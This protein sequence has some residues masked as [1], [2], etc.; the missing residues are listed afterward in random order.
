MPFT[1][2]P[3]LKTK[4]GEATALLHLV[5]TEKDRIAPI[6]HVAE[7]PPATFAARMAAAWAG[8]TCFLDGTFNFNGSGSST[9]F[10]NTFLALGTGGIPVVPVIE[11]GAAQGYNHAAYAHLNQFGAGLMLK[12]TPGTLPSAVNFAQQMQVPQSQ[13]D[14]LVDAGHISEYDPVSFAGYVSHILQTNLPGASW[15]SMTLGSSAAPKDFGQLGL[16]TTIVPRTD[17]LM[18]SNLIQTPTLPIDFADF[19]ISHRDLTEP[20]GVAMASAT[21]SVRYTVADN[22]V[23]IK[24]RRT[25]GATGVPMGNQYRA[26]AQTLI[27]RPDFGGLPAC[28]ADQRITAIATTSISAGGRAQWVEIN[29]NRHF[30]FIS[31]T[32][33]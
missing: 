20:P 26:H 27:A 3:M 9:D 17:W 1:Y 10:D 13:I 2:R 8:R 28:W 14:L 22:W 33:P 16:G 29:A 12:C 11:I 24:G 6:F 5:A 23:M 18:W 32:L 31:N 15:R 19:G 21:V 30:S 4:A 7:T 25:T